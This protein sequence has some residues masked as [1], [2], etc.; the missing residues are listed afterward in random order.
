MEFPI[1]DQMTLF[2][3]F[4]V[5][6]IIVN[7]VSLSYGYNSSMKYTNL[8][9]GYIIGIIWII[10]IGCMAYAQ[11]QV[12]LSSKKKWIEWLIPLLFLYCILYPFYTY[13][14]SNKCISKIA[15]IGTILFSLFIVIILYNI[16]MHS[17][18]GLIGLT[19]IWSSYATWSTW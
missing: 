6:A 17:A 7:I 5:I 19:T 9:P 11:S 8:P 4:I 3:L 1:R 13:G 12:L 14:F 15:N 16:S 2:I 18:A 10:L